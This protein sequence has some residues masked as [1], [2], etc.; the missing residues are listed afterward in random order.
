MISVQ[1]LILKI[2]LQEYY[3]T[4][5]L[6]WSKLPTFFEKRLFLRKIWD[7][8][9]K[10][11][12]FILF[13]SFFFWN[14]T[15]CFIHIRFLQNWNQQIDTMVKILVSSFFFPIFKAFN[16]SSYHVDRTSWN[17]FIHTHTLVSNVLWNRRMNFLKQSLI[18]KIESL[19]VKSFCCYVYYSAIASFTFLD[20]FFAYTANAWEVMAQKIVVNHCTSLQ[21]IVQQSFNFRRTKVDAVPS[22]RST[23]TRNVFYLPCN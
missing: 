7:S 20:W 14:N 1:F 17:S 9:E 22:T 15:L 19:V 11:D 5:L 23:H 8:K 4:S 12:F 18:Q 3:N 21:T 2:I 10:R 16:F 13:H 6:L